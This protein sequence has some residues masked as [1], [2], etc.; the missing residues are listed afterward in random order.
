MRRTAV[1]LVVLVLLAAAAVSGPSERAE[2]QTTPQT[3][4]SNLGQLS[5]AFGGDTFDHAQA[6]TTGDHSMGYTLT[7]V[8]IHF[9][10]IDSNQFLSNSGFTI[11]SDSG[12]NP[13]TVLATLTDPPSQTGLSVQHTFTVPG[14]GLDLDPNTQYWVVLDN[15]ATSPGD[16]QISNTTSDNEDAGAA[17]GWSINNGSKYRNWNT[18]GGW[19]DLG[20]SRL[21]RVNGFLIVPPP[22]PTIPPLPQ[23]N[24]EGL[25]PVLE[26]W[27]LIP[28]DLEPGDTFRLLFMT[29]TRHDAT[30]TDIEDYNEHVQLAAASNQAQVAIKKYAGGF[31][32]VGC[33]TSVTARANT[34]SEASDPDAPIYW[35]NGVKLA[36]D[37]AD[38]YDNTWD[39]QV[40]ASIREETGAPPSSISSAWTGCLST[41]LADTVKGE[42]GNNLSAALGDAGSATSPLSH[43]FA[44]STESF[45]LYAMSPVFLVEAQAA[46]NEGLIC[47]CWMIIVRRGFCFGCARRVVRATRTRGTTIRIG[48]RR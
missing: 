28:S 10:D 46:Y 30:P 37:Y 19:N 16:N 32:V 2:A 7:S 33:T 48:C 34:A 3:L 18:N 23:A 47:R 15:T 22:P 4:V 35:L 38:F 27:P 17:S 40:E 31:K 14:Q 6:F 20:A 9:R 11:R 12:G 1:A 44:T 13:G 25:Y 8:D 42:L 43:S 36:D 39:N 21:I 24:P 41:G 5:N 29:S 26:D 45:S